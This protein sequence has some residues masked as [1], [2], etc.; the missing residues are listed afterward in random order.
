MS[1]PIQL[2]RHDGKRLGLPQ[3]C[4]IFISGLSD[5]ARAEL[6]MPDAKTLILA[7]LGTGQRLACHLRDS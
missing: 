5:A 1:K 6:K 7:D 2:T 3:M 4:A